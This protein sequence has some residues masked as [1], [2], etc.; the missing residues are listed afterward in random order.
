R[1][2][3]VS[4]SGN[5]D[6]RNILHIARSV[7]EV[8]EETGV[9]AEQA[10]ATIERAKERLRDHRRLRIRPGLDDK[11][12]AAWNGLAIRALA[13]AGAALPNPRYLDA[14]RQGAR[15]AL[16]RLVRPDGTLAR[17]WAKGRPGEVNGFLDDYA[18]TALGLFAL[19]AA[20]GETE[21]FAAG[22]DLT[23]R[24]ETLFAD[25]EGGLF[26]S[27]SSDLIKRPQDLLD[28]PSPSGT[29]L[30]AEACLVLSL[31]TG[32][33][34]L[35][36]RAGGYLRSLGQIIER[37]PSAA[38][39]ALAVLL[40]LDRGTHELAVVGADA[41]LVGAPYWQRY[42]P[43]IVIATS[44][45]QPGVEIPLLERRGQPGRTLAYLCT[46][47]TCLAPVDSS[48]RLSELLEST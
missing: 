37:Y 32:D 14:A 34:D 7:A 23:L 42:R 48:A 13:E 27:S 10:A 33:P 8:A 4:P 15:F 18:A 2:F 38:G 12:V 20:T 28:T 40:S 19:Y 24:I 16:T 46:G 3:G 36:D 35:R 31:Y 1:H 41:R 29:S 17:T 39:H 9:S 22:R 45:G 43:H 11:V 5:F 44:E 6:G 25:G 47:F 30:A 26:A 21:W